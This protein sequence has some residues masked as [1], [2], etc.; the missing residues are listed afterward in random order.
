MQRFLQRNRK[1]KKTRRRR[2]KDGS[3]ANQNS[4]SAMTSVETST[5]RIPLLYSQPRFQTVP[6]EKKLRLKTETPRNTGLSN[7]SDTSSIKSSPLVNWLLSEESEKSL[8]TGNYLFPLSFILP[9]G[10]LPTSASS[11]AS[12]W[13]SGLAK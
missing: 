8:A 13:G 10:E 9:K 12:Q 4:E 3:V 11:L 1:D 6:P 7:N 2:V 5:E